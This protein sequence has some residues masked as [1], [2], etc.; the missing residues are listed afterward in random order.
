MISGFYQFGLTE[1]TIFLFVLRV[2]MKIP[3]N[4]YSGK[5]SKIYPSCSHN[6]EKGWMI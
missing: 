2:L 4:L 5:K 6:I 3:H 1:K